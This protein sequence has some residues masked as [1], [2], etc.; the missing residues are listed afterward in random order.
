MLRTNLISSALVALVSVPGFL[1]GQK[2]RAGDPSTLT[3]A[4][5]MMMVVLLASAIMRQGNR[6]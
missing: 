2:L 5:V 4:V 1:L 3:L 6:A